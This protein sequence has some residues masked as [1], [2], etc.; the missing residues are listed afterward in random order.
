[1][2]DTIV[3]KKLLLMLEIAEP[4]YTESLGA[5]EDGV[6]E[7]ISD[8]IEGGFVKTVVTSAG[9]SMVVVDAIVVTDGEFDIS[10]VVS[11]LGKVMVDVI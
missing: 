4:S 5:E 3:S 1:M 10:V 7:V 8:N 9:I 2:K 6:L 11:P